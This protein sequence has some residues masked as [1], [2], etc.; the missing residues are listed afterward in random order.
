MVLL[1]RSVLIN[2]DY[3]LFR[4]DFDYVMIGEVYTKGNMKISLAKVKGWLYLVKT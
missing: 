1:F 4:V 3:V 2:E